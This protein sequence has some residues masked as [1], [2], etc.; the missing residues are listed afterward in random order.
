MKLKIKRVRAGFED[1]PLPEYKTKGSA[2][3]D[4][5][6]AIEKEIILNPGE[7]VKVP[8]NLAVAVPAGYEMQIRSRS[9]LALNNQIVELNS[10][11]TI[12]SDY[13]GEVCLI[14]HN[15]GK[16]TF[17]I[18]RGMRL[19]QALITPVVQ[20]EIVEVEELDDTERGEGGFGSTGRM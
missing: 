7:T 3:M 20:P 10:P 5:R 12:D 11:G 18:E 9:G 6:A 1:V 19:V 4:L 17:V 14:I 15:L 2:G 13:R 8:T 16:E